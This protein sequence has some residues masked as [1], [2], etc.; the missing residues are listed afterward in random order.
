MTSSTPTLACL[1]VV[2]A[3][4]YNHL[5]ARG[6]WI[7]EWWIWV[8]FFQQSYWH[9]PGWRCSNCQQH[10]S[11]T[12][13][14]YC[15]VLSIY[16]HYFLPTSPSRNT[17]F[18]ACCQFGWLIGSGCQYHSNTHTVRCWCALFSCGFTTS[19][20]DGATTCGRLSRMTSLD[21]LIC[22]EDTV[23]MWIWSY[24]YYYWS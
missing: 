17:L 15:N 19:I 13:E 12:P 23:F 18:S 5:I 16:N 9:W 24:A 20:K 22:S 7:A 6:L 21:L 10:S 2:R 4:F 8:G 14:R 11:A 3:I 1:L